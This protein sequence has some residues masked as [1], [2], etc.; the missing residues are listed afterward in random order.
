MPELKVTLFT[1]T[2]KLSF[3]LTILTIISMGFF[4]VKLLSTYTFYYD[5]VD[6][7][8]FN[9]EVI[10]IPITVIFLYCIYRLYRNIEALGTTKLKISLRWS[11]ISWFIPIYNLWKPYQ[12]MKDI[13]SASD[14][15]LPT[16]SGHIWNGK[17]YTL[18]LLL[19]WISYNLSQIVL[20]IPLFMSVLRIDIF[21]LELLGLFFLVISEVSFI[22]ILAQIGLGQG[23]RYKRTQ[24]S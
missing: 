7:M 20:F 24:S 16:R 9:E 2:A 12:V 22:W 23:I 5:V 15:D 21:P 13:W 4:V 14:P 17:E 10:S 19:W 3:I 1:S 18:L 8:E 6:L 11:I